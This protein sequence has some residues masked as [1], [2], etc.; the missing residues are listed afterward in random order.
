MLPVHGQAAT[1]KTARNLG[2]ARP[3]LGRAL[4]PPGVLPVNDK[5]QSNATISVRKV[6]CAPAG[7]HAVVGER[8]LAF[9]GR[10]SG[11]QNR[12]QR[13]TD[14][15]RPVAGV[16]LAT[17]NGLLAKAHR[18][19]TEGEVGSPEDAIQAGK[20]AGAEAEHARTG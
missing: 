11:M 4:E 16:N 5:M 20:V 1:A 7:V 19:S 3:S 10:S 8:E 2:T 14:K 6:V 12:A 17:P 18:K 9:L 15:V 13:M